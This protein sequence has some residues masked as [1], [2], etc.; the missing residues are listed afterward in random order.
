M[1]STR[2]GLREDALY[3]DNYERIACS[4]CEET[5]KRENDPDEVYAVRTCPNCGKQ[6]KEL[7]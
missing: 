6:W 7:P 3:K 1:K 4:E 2:K 5:L